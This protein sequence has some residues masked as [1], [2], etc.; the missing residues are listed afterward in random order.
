MFPE[1]FAGDRNGF[2]ASPADHGIAR[3]RNTRIVIVRPFLAILVQETCRALREGRVPKRSRVIVRHL[4]QNETFTSRRALLRGMV[5]SA[6]VLALGGCANL[7][8]TGARYDAASLSAEPTVLVATTRKPVNGGRTKPWFGPERAT[9]M[10][11]ARAKLVAPD[12]SRFSLAAAGL[13]DWRLDAVEPASG[14][15]S[16]LLTQGGGGDVL[17]YVHGFKQTFETA[18]LDAAHLADGIKFRGQTMV[19]SWPSKAGLF[20]YAYDR[21]SAMWSRDG[22][23][24]VLQSAI[25][26]PGVGRVHIVAHS[27]GTML[28]LESLRQLYARNGDAVTDKIGAVVFASPDI[29]MDVFSSAVVRIGPLGRKITVVAATNDRALAL[30]G[31]LAGGVT[32]VGAAEKAAIERLGV[33]V[34]DASEAGWGIINHDLFLS[35][36]EVRRVIRRSIDTSAV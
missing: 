22:F 4:M 24:R 6:S 26:T 36:A 16:D 28:T 11:V 10:T 5:S 21:D 35:N 14:E 8:A 2:I 31:R 7:G 9:R 20:D 25:T 3:N 13:G 32:R 23:E 15:V 27:M 17:V 18:A 1:D 12:E 30:S 29:D 34:I 33:R 19:F